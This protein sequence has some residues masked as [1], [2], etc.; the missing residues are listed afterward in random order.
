MIDKLM[1]YVL[2]KRLLVKTLIAKLFCKKGLHLK[3]AAIT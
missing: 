2:G 3:R 1:V